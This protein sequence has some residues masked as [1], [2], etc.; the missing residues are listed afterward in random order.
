MLLCSSVPVHLPAASK[1]I[2]NVFFIR[3]GVPDT[4]FR[5][6]LQLEESGEKER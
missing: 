4:L 5:R 1:R 3:D 2:T 6:T